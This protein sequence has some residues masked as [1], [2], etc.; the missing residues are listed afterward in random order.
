ME[1]LHQ[2]AQQLHPNTSRGYIRDIEVD[3]SDTES[4]LCRSAPCTQGKI[5]QLGGGRL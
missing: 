3:H 1:V 5:S 2:L 4:V